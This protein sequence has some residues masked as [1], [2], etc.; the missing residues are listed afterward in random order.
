MDLAGIDL[1]QFLI[2]LKGLVKKISRSQPLEI[3]SHT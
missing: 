1:Q 3:K 2:K